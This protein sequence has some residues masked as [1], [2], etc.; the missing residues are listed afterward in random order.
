[1]RNAEIAFSRDD[2]ARVHESL[3]TALG[4]DPHFGRAFELRGRTLYLQGRQADAVEL[5]RQ[6]IALDPD[7]HRRRILL[8]AMLQ[9]V[10]RPHEAA[11]TLA[12]LLDLDP[13]NVQTRL[14]LDQLQATDPGPAPR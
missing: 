5:V 1:M 10:G 6:A 13:S 11:T 14:M 9:G 2:Y 7:A 4:L 12:E 3:D 8:A